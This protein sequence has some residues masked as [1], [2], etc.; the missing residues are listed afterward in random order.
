MNQLRYAIVR[1][2][3]QGKKKCDISRLLQVPETTVRRA[4]KRYQ[5]TGNNEDRPRS[6]RPKTANTATNRKKIKGLIGSNPRLSTRKL[7]KKTK[8]SRISVQRILKNCLQ[9]K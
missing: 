9:L 4:I 6:G 5:D 1:L 7:S 8:I 2:F 3:Q